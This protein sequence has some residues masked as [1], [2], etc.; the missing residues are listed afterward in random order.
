[1]DDETECGERCEGNTSFCGSHNRQLRREKE[2]DRKQIE[3]KKALLERAKN[4]TVKDLKDS[5]LWVPFSKYIR[6]RDSDENG[7]CTCFTC[8]DRQE[9]NSGGMQAGHFVGRRHWSTR[10]HEQ[11][12]HAQCTRC[13]MYQSGMQ[14]EYGLKLDQKYGEGTAQKLFELS[15]QTVHMNQNDIDGLAEHYRYLVKEKL[16]GLRVSRLQTT[17]PHKI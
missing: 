11:N 8:G 15:K 13:N 5:N 4:K 7:I 17:E 10:Y 9:W 2:S 3:K 14:Y 12:V 16:N 1:M 6:L